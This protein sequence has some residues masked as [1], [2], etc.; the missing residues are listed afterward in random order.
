MEHIVEQV[1]SVKLQARIRCSKYLRNSFFVRSSTLTEMFRDGKD[2]CL[3]DGFSRFPIEN[4]KL[5]QPL[6]KLKTDLANL[7]EEDSFASQI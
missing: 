1:Y 6:K 5:V 3:A 4:D 2:N 7:Q